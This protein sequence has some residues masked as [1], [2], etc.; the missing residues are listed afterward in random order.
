[1]IRG[2]HFEALQEVSGANGAGA[3]SKFERFV[4]ERK[5][6]ANEPAT[7]GARLDGA[8]KA[9]HY[10]RDVK[11][12]RIEICPVSEYAAHLHA[13]VEYWKDRDEIIPNTPEM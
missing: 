4:V 9:Q 11:H 12:G 7:E 13:F 10:V 5:G 1:M 8:V 2:K 3:P 6:K